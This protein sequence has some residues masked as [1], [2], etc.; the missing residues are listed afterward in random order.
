MGSY[1][2]LRHFGYRLHDG[3]RFLFGRF[4]VIRSVRALWINPADNPALLV[5]NVVIPAG[6]AF[7]LPRSLEGLEEPI[8]FVRHY[9]TLAILSAKIKT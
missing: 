5:L 2:R 6:V 9:W 3:Q 1:F 8:P 4:L 7:D